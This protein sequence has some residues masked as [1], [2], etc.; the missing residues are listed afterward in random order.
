MKRGVVV[1][2]AMLRE[3]LQ[4]LFVQGAGDCVQ[5]PLE[6]EGAAL[7]FAIELVEVVPEPFD[8]VLPVARRSVENHVGLHRWRGL[9]GR[10][11]RLRQLL[12][13]D[14]HDSQVRHSLTHARLRKLVVLGDPE[15]VFEPAPYLRVQAAVA[16]VGRQTIDLRL[17]D[18]LQGALLIRRDRG[19]GRGR[20]GQGGVISLLVHAEE[21]FLQHLEHVPCAIRVQHL[22]MAGGS[23]FEPEGEVA[24]VW[25][26]M[27]LSVSKFSTQ[28]RKA[29]SSPFARV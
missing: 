11:G 22:R 17:D 3:A 6:G 14:L 15:M 21:S 25:S 10:G 2:I 8:L 12:P 1:E 4:D 19:V 20:S 26:G 18:G 27:T 23:A 9:L 24:R 28:T 5:R 13:P 7:K 29:L 16:L